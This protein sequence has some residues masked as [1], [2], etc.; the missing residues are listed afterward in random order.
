M[1]LPPAQARARLQFL[2][3]IQAAKGPQQLLLQQFA[4]YSRNS[5][6]LMRTATFGF[7]TTRRSQR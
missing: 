3:Q 1:Q 6:Q 7:G 2:A 5:E 4:E